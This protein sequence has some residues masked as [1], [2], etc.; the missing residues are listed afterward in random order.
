MKQCSRH[1]VASLVLALVAVAASAQSAVTVAG[2]DLSA[3]ASGRS[4]SL[5]PYGDPDN[6][7]VS[8]VWDFR[9]DG[10]VCARAAGTKA[11]DPCADE[12]R[13]SIKGDLLCWELSWYGAS[14]GFKTACSS[15][16]ALTGERLELRNEKAPDL[17]YM[18]ARPR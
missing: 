1:R 7:A 14:Y 4:W 8:M 18:V 3:L 17:T 5:S 15:V 11:G 10:S 2:R 6:P 16:R 9:S 12:G 13:W